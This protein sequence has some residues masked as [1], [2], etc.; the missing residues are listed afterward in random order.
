[1][2]AE[3]VVFIKGARAGTARAL[4]PERGWRPVLFRYDE[5]YIAALDRTPLSV[6]VPVDAGDAEIGDWLD[7]LLP[8][9]PDVRNYWADRE[10]AEGSDAVSMLSTPI[11]LD[12]AGA[13]QFCVPGNESA[14]TTRTFGV[15]WLTE[16]EIADWIRD[17]K[18]GG[19]WNHLGEHG[20]Y[21]L[22]GYQ[23]KIAL[24]H[25]GGR[26]GVPFGQLPTT[27]ILKP[28]IDP[29]PR[30]RY[31]DSDI[32]EHITM[33]AAAEIGLDVAATRIERFEAERVL[34]VERYDR[35]AAETGLSRMHQEDLC[36]ALGRPPAEKYQ[37]LGGPT[38][39]RDR[40][41]DPPRG[42]RRVR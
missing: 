7:G 10:D 22:G 17:A 39:G 34:V 24:Y 2:A 23:T 35:L 6:S 12:C 9:D 16:T 11:G 13:V 31:D 1:M 33:A 40:R 29:T 32:I 18:A 21:S 3:L 41:P 8:D 15:D 28:G 38:T 20:W 14:V 4:A 30:R 19:R 27:H 25:G 37:S 36:Q 26:W 5:A 42:R